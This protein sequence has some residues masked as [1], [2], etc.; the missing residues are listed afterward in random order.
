MLTI[1][2]WFA[3]LFIKAEPPEPTTEIKALIEQM[4][5]ENFETRIEAYE[6]LKNFKYLALKGCLAK[7]YHDDPEI[8]YRCRQL[9]E[10]YYDSI[11]CPEKYPSIYLLSNK[12]RFP[13]GVS[14][15]ISKNKYSDLKSP[16]DLAEFYFDEARELWNQHLDIYLHI[17]AEIRRQEEIEA[18]AMKLYIRNLIHQ[19]KSKE[20]I[21]QILTEANNSV[22][23]L[24]EEETPLW[25]FQKTVAGPAIKKN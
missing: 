22:N 13:L 21:T 24:P 5:A 12:Y 15:K 2:F 23:L 7:S 14:Y 17:E 1:I 18:N 6:K 25:I 4:G 16:I 10:Q 3:T 9:V 11:C 19:G 8:A 20:F